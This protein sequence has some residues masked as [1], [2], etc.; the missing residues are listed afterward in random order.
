MVMISEYY[1]CFCLF[2]IFAVWNGCHIFLFPVKKYI[3]PTLSTLSK[4]LSMSVAYYLTTKSPQSN[5]V[6]SIYC[7]ISS[8]ILNSFAKLLPETLTLFR[9]WN[10][11]R[12]SLAPIALGNPRHQVQSVR[13]WRESEQ[14]VPQQ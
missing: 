11:G 3:N 14:Q 8:F 12:F 5:L 4:L 7:L 6:T 10:E 2:M 13:R 9:R 1:V